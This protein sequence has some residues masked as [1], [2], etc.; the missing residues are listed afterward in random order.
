M[1]HFHI[2]IEVL[3]SKVCLYS[4]L[5]NNAAHRLVHNMTQKPTKRKSE[6]S[7]FQKVFYGSNLLIS[8]SLN[9]F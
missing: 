8:R 5:V 7:L 9:L 2:A 6:N 3:R 4:M 1:V